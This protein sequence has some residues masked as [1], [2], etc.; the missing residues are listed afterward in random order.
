MLDV[1]FEEAEDF[2]GVDCGCR[3]LLGI[4]AEVADGLVHGDEVGVF[5]GEEFCVECACYCA[6]AEEGDAVAD[7]FFFAEGYDFD[8][9]RELALVCDFYEFEGEG[10][11]EDAVEGAR[12]W[13]GV[14]VGAEDEAFLACVGGL[15]E[16]AE[17]AG[18][19]RVDGHAEGNHASEE[20]RVD[21]VG[22]WGEEAAGDA[23]WLLGEGGEVEALGDGSG[24]AGLYGLVHSGLVRSC[25]WGRG[26][27]VPF[28]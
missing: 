5:Q 9:E 12:V 22:G 21:L 18:G 27:H 3:D 7:A 17:V 25:P 26:V 23:A 2:F 14:D 11:A 24:G 8:G 1:D 4:K 20:M 10:Y 19:V 13:D 16:A 15:V 6:A 28:A